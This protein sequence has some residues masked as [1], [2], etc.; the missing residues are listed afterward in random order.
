M[1]PNFKLSIELHEHAIFY[2][3][4]Y[5]PPVNNI[6]GSFGCIYPDGAL[7]GVA[8]DELLSLGPGTHDIKMDERNRTP[9]GTKPALNDEEHQLELFRM[10]AFGYKHGVF[11]ETDLLQHALLSFTQTNAET[12]LKISP[13]FLM[14]SLI[15]HASRVPQILADRTPDSFDFFSSAGSTRIPDE[16]LQLL[17][18]KLSPENAG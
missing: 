6:G 4:N 2:H 7:L 15:E 11:T 1:L 18:Q 10:V 3:W 17:N 16:N 9:T 14:Q 12:V 5:S 13:D 8:F